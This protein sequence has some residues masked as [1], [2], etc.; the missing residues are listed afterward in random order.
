MAV[1]LFATLL[2][3][4]VASVSLR[5]ARPSALAQAESAEERAAW[6]SAAAFMLLMASAHVFMRRTDVLMLGWFADTTA[7]G[8][9][10]VACRITELISF[11]L[12][13]INIIFAPTISA[14]YARGD[15]ANLQALVTMTA[16]WAAASALAVALPLFIFAEPLLRLFGAAFVDG[17][18]A[19]RILLIGQLI[20]AAAGSVGYLM[21]MTALERQAAFIIVAAMVGNIGLNAALI[22]AFGMAGAAVVNTVT[23]T[24]WNIAMAVLLWKKLGIVP[25]ILG[26]AR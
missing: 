10:T 13:A 11:A 4:G 24:A 2:S 20:N 19:I 12:T 18:D 15:H 25:S 22:P 21:T 9:Y 16:W 5:R 17:A 7:A 23:T 26:S 8:I 1:T 3:L 14:L 6:R